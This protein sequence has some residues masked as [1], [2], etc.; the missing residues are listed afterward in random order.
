MSRA[1]LAEDTWKRVDKINAELFIL[2]YGSIV[3]QLCTD[4]EEYSEVNKIL[5][6]MGYDMGIRLIEDFL[7]R[8]SQGRCKDLR[9]TAEVISK[10]PYTHLHL[11]TVGL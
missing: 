4:C 9:D 8:T 1:K 3:A 6:K 7:A 10:V 5:E 2:T 11:T